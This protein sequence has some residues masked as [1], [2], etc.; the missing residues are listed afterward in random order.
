MYSSLSVW[1]EG[2]GVELRTKVSKRGSLTG[3]QLCERDCWKGEVT[4]S[5]GLASLQNKK[6]KKI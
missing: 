5:R 1:R 6:E 2:G 4:F 3:L